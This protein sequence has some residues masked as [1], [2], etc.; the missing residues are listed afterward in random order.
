MFTRAVAYLIAHELALAEMIA[1]EGASSG[2]ITSGAIQSEKEGD[3]ERSYGSVEGS[4][5]LYDKT[6]YGRM[7]LSIRKICIVPVTVR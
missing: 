3:L 4:N 6:S 1:D 2:I 5:T 7:F